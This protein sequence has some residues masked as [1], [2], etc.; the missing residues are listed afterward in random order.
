MEFCQQLG[1]QFDS[2]MWE[3]SLTSGIYRVGW[4]EVGGESAAAAQG[5]G[6]VRSLEEHVDNAVRS[7]VIEELRRIDDLEEFIA[8]TATDRP[9][10]LTTIESL[11]SSLATAEIALEAANQKLLGVAESVSQDIDRACVRL[12]AALLSGESRREVAGP[13][14]LWD[15]G[16]VYAIS[17]WG[18]TPI[19]KGSS[20]A[21]LLHD[22]HKSGRQVVLVKDKTVIGGWLS[23]PIYR[24]GPSD[25]SGWAR[26]WSL[27]EKQERGFSVDPPEYA[28]SV[29][30]IHQ[31]LA[32]SS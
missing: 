28:D 10:L 17:S 30:R 14:V 15:D 21:I 23:G 31:V 18:N 19:P 25:I 11:R 29:R 27:R 4:L 16:V 12:A 24:R 1:I 7:T 8:R 22:I 2:T 32:S 6:L 13:L 26:V 20:P 9:A 3:G 5:L